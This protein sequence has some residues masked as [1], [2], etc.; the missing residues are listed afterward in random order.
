MRRL[1]CLLALLALAVPAAAPAVAASPTV[2]VAKKFRPFLPWLRDRSGLK[3]LLPGRVDLG[4]PARKLY[5]S[6]KI[7]KRG[8]YELELAGAKNCNGANVCFIAFFSA[9]R[10]GRPDTVN[11]GLDRGHH[12][13]FEDL[14]CGASCSPPSISW[15][16]GHVLYFIQAKLPTPNGRAAL[17]RIANSAIRGG[18]R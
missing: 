15:V 3:V 9:T 6:A 13:H 2:D 4:F 18:A 17:I 14:H 16:Q 7:P 1:A 10:D 11:V 12:G 5:A 8:V